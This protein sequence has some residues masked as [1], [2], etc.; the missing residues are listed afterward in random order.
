MRE[1]GFDDSRCGEGLWALFGLSEKCRKM[2]DV[3]RVF[4]VIIFFQ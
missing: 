2:E 3:I 1:R 4:I